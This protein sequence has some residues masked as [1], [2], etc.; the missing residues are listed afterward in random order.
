MP[1]VDILFRIGGHM[2]VFLIT[3]LVLVSAL[4]TGYSQTSDKAQSKKSEQQEIPKSVSESVSSTL[5]YTEDNILGL[6]EA[7]PEHKYSFIP[8]N[9]NFSGVRSF[10]KQIK[11]VACA[12]FAFL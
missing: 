5:Q 10:S 2:K 8:T 4:A 9:G 1:S 6:A 7:M 3:A 11:N 12:Q